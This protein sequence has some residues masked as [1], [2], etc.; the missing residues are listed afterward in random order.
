MRIKVTTFLFSF[1]R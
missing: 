1:I